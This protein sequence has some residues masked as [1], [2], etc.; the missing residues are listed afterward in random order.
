M[1][2]QQRL[3]GFARR[4]GS[5]GIVAAVGVTFLC[6]L[7][8]LPA[9]AA[10]VYDYTI[11]YPGPYQV[12]GSPTPVS[13]TATATAPGSPSG[14]LTE[15]AFA[16]AGPGYLGG[17]SQTTLDLPNGALTSEGGTSQESSDFTLDN[18]VITGPAGSTSAD[19]VDYSINVSV[20]GSLSAVADTGFH[21]QAGVSLSVSTNSSLGGGGGA[22][23]S[24][25]VNSAGTVTAS[26][27]FSSFPVGVTGQTTAVSPV[28]QARSGDTISIQLILAT[29]AIAGESFGSPAGSAAATADFS[30]TVMFPT[31]GPVLNLPAGWTAN[32]LDGTIVDNHFVAS[33]PEPAALWLLGVAI[34]AGLMR[35]RLQRLPGAPGA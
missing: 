20:M 12:L 29:F 8:S 35:R 3:R 24:M 23:G 33:I 27:V 30:H 18:I 26:G 9:H 25:T 5:V 2:S 17:L 7:G 34:A 19:I 16:S 14:L 1:V 31:S 6:A 32:S 10:P 11:D 21:S 22:L 4:F 13:F 28:H 15:E